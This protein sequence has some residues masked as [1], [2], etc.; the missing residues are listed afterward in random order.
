MTGSSLPPSLQARPP[1]G[2][3][4]QNRCLCPLP[5]ETQLA[6]SQPACRPQRRR[7]KGD[8]RHGTARPGPAG[9][10]RAGGG[11]HGHPKPSAGAGSRALS[12]AQ[13]PTPRLSSFRDR[14]DLPW[15]S[16]LPSISC[17]LR[18]AGDSPRPSCLPFRQSESEAMA[19]SP[20]PGPPRAISLFSCR[21]VVVPSPSRDGGGL[22]L[23]PSLAPPPSAEP[24]S[25]MAAV[26]LRPGNPAPARRTG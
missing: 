3:R 4:R 1:T 17:R 18:A 23:L 8:R 7:L 9:S 14:S 21:A 16:F 2:G 25:K 24:S 19:P 22:C 12:W 15:S 20:T 6:S 13:Q 11:M 26:W 10:P 5:G